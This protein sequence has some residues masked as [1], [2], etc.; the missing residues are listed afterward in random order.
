MVMLISLLAHTKM[1]PDC[2]HIG[3]TSSGS[4]HHVLMKSKA[5]LSSGLKMA[6]TLGLLPSTSVTVATQSDLLN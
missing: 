4:G 5:P 3:L 2:G 6:K 1:L